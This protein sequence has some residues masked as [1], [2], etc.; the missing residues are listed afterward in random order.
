MIPRGVKAQPRNT[1][2]NYPS[3]YPITTGSSVPA[4][5]SGRNTQSFEELFPKQTGQLIKIGQDTTALGQIVTR[6]DATDISHQNQINEA[7]EHRKKIDANLQAALLE[8]KDFHTKLNQKAN[9]GHTHAIANGKDCG[10]FGEKCWLDGLGWV[11]WVALGA[12][13]LLVLWLVR[14]LLK[15]GANVTK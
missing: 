9:V 6:Q 3:N 7:F 8:H 13:A 4:T 1:G 11:K 5:T 10:W 2:F 15:I 14:P 12:V